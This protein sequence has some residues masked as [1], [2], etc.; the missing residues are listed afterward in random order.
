MF[1]ASRGVVGCR[2]KKNRWSF[3]V[4]EPKKKVPNTRQAEHKAWTFDVTRLAKPG[5][6]AGG[7]PSQLNIICAYRAE[8]V[9]AR[10][11]HVGVPRQTMTQRIVQSASLDRGNNRGTSCAQGDLGFF[12]VYLGARD[13]I[14]TEP[15]QRDPRCSVTPIRVVSRR[16]LA[17]GTRRL[18]AKVGPISDIV[19]E[20][21]SLVPESVLC[22]FQ[23]LGLLCLVIKL[24]EGERH[25]G[26]AMGKACQIVWIAE[27]M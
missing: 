21:V 25:P 9:V 1:L 6:C 12:P 4:G 19:V 24:E 5:D 14:C 10:H 3:G 13:L 15:R 18:L 20:E 16:A 7:L 8:Y 22:C 26:R 23:I 11:Q 27:R 2:H 17:A